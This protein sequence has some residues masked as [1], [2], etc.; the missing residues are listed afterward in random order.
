V[1]SSPAGINCGNTCSASFPTGSSVTLTATAPSGSI[2]DGWSGGGCSG[3]GTC[4]T[5]MATSQTVVATFSLASTLTVNKSGSGN[6]TVT[7]NPAGINCGGECSQSYEQ[8]TVVTLTATPNGNSNFAGWSGPCSGT[9]TCTI[10]LT[11]NTTVGAQ[12]TKK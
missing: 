9:G 5:V 12:F 6:G 11:A 10:A 1:T 2:F 7:S 8:G 4:T 3:T